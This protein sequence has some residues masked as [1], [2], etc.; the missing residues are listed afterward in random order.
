MKLS[1]AIIT[2]DNELFH[3]SLCSSKHKKIFMDGKIIDI[4]KKAREEKIVDFQITNQ[5]NI[6]LR[7]LLVKTYNEKNGYLKIKLENDER[8]QFNKDE[9]IQNLKLVTSN[10]EI[11]SFIEAYA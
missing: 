4:I 5:N 2:K 7:I 9:N 1:Q 3:Y 11:K 8:R 10:N 6:R